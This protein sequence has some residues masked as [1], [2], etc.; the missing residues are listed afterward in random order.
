MHFIWFF[1]LFPLNNNWIKIQEEGCQRKNNKDICIDECN[2]S[3]VVKISG[4]LSTD[5]SVSLG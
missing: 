5:G 1:R 2:K 3:K 4:F